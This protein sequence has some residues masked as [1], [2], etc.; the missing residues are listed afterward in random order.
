MS[1]KTVGSQGDVTAVPTEGNA[2]QKQGMRIS[3][4]M[5]QRPTLN[6]PDGMSARKSEVG[7]VESSSRPPT[8]P[9]KE[10]VKRSR[11][12]NPDEHPDDSS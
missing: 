1:V 2:L 5:E 3:G 10:G 11:A 6:V 12:G 8:P 7:E 4:N 9:A